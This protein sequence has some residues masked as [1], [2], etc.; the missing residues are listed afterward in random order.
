VV[1]AVS[2]A[3]VATAVAVVLYT[4]SSR[5]SIEDVEKGEEK[6]NLKK[7]KAKSSKTKKAGSTDSFDPNGPILEEV[8]K[9]DTPTCKLIF[10]STFSYLCLSFLNLVAPQNLTDT[11]INGLTPQVRYSQHFMKNIRARGD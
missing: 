8:H 5:A 3:A 2:A 6:K 7:K 10:V 1:L 11:E 9:D 4:N